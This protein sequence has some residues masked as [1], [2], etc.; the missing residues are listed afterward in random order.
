M[1]PFCLHRQNCAT[2]LPI[3]CVIS[4]GNVGPWNLKCGRDQKNNSRPV[5][6]PPV[7][8]SILPSPTK[9]C[10]TSSD[11]MRHFMRQ[12]RP[13]ELEMR[14]RPEK[15]LA[16]RAPTARPWFHFAFTDKTV[17]HVF[18]SDASFHAATSAP[19]T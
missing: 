3:G 6:Q 12:R 10:H 14:T 19:G 15:Q 16:P 8:G 13:L 17:P 1:V 4:C 5:H 9:L 18:R 11:R 2:R 7:H